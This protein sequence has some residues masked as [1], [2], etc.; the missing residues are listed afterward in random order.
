MFGPNI[1]APR[2]GRWICR[3]IVSCYT[4]SVRPERKGGFVCWGMQWAARSANG[5]WWRRGRDHRFLLKGAEAVCAARCTFPYAETSPSSSA[6]LIPHAPLP[7]QQQ[8]T[9]ALFGEALTDR[10]Q[11]QTKCLLTFGA[12]RSPEPT[13][14]QHLPCRPSRRGHAHSPTIAQ[15]V[16][17]CYL[18]TRGGASDVALGEKNERRAN[19]RATTSFDHT[20][21]FS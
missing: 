13:G 11:D 8:F 10:E 3:V 16:C 17:L 5:R 7:R 21:R 6:L 4:R 18:H 20:T 2:F 14:Q 15:L 9:A 12:P 1:P 19:E